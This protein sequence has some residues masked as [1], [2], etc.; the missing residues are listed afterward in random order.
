MEADTAK[1]VSM[2]QASLFQCTEP[3]EALQLYRCPI[4]KKFNLTTED[5]NDDRVDWVALGEVVCGRECHTEAYDLMR[6]TQPLLPL[7]D[8]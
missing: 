6:T 2:H 3:R 8:P 4:C 5:P 1:E 7:H